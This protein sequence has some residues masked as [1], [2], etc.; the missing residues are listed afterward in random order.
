[1]SDV[2]FD[3]TKRL[4]EI[5]KKISP[6]VFYGV[7]LSS[8]DVIALQ[9]ELGDIIREVKL[10]VKENILFHRNWDAVSKTQNVIRFQSKKTTDGGCDE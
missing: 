6:Y 1:M 10:I 5:R 9:K 2:P 8:E 3:V 4:L 7:E